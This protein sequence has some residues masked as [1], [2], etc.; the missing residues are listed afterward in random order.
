MVA[1]AQDM[2]V[3]DTKD[4]CD[5]SDFVKLQGK[6]GQVSVRAGESKRV[7]LPA[8]TDEINWFCGGDRNRSAN[9]EHFNVVRVSR[10]A[11]GAITWVFFK[12][13][14]QPASD[15]V[16]VG[17]TKD[18]CDGSRQVRF[19][20]AGGE[21]IRVKAGESKLARLTSP[22][23]TLNWLCVPSGGACPKD[24]TCDESSSNSIPFDA[25]QIERAGNGAISWVFYL[26]KNSAPGGGA[27]PGFVRNANGDVRVGI[28]AGPLGKKEIPLAPGFLKTALDRVWNSRREEIRAFV[29][30]ELIR[31]GEEA[32][33]KLPGGSFH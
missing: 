27:V 17:D 19:N 25:V 1:S 32:A 10:A 11:N 18:A 22:R 7:E 4:G 33:R 9:D 12:S 20:A 6:A 13:S 29:R 5:K 2:K 8:L 28:S 21:Q 23:N 3:G 31:Q 15:L 30:A 24:D 26:K 16:R 14:A